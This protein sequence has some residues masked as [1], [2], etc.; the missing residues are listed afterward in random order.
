MKNIIILI[1]LSLNASLSWASSCPANQQLLLIHTTMYPNSVIWLNQHQNAIPLTAKSKQQSVQFEQSS[2]ASAPLI[3]KYTPKQNFIAS[4]QYQITSPQMKNMGLNPDNYQ[5]EVEKNIDLAALQWVEKPQLLGYEISDDDPQFGIS[6]QIYFSL[7]TN[8]KPE[9]YLVLVHLIDTIKSADPQSFIL[10][11][12]ATP[13]QKN[14]NI[15]QITMGFNPCL[16]TFHFQEN[17]EIWAKFDLITH[18]GK[19]IP[20][21]S[22][23]LKI[24][25][26]PSSKQSTVI[27]ESSTQVQS[28]S[29]WQEFK[30]WFLNLFKLIFSK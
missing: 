17:D 15:A 11:P 29:W 26:K 28:L 23:A 10:Q 3:L 19:I 27:S 12:F 8:L 13:E 25:I 7:Q 30:N 5:F 1:T 16:S 9:N 20:W 6:G 24:S 2:I 18:D 14:E 21:D 4:Q 22:E